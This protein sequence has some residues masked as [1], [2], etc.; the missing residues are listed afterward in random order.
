V[1]RVRNQEIWGGAALEY[2]I[3]S[4][5]G[6]VVAVAAIAYVIKVAKSKIADLEQKTGI[7]FNWQIEKGR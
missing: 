1:N 4:T 6:L 3:V 2:L 7:T 5:F